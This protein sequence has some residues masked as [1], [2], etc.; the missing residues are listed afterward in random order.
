LSTKSTAKGG[1]PSSTARLYS[2]TLVREFCGARQMATVFC[3]PAW[4][5]WAT[6]SP[7]K[8]FQLRMPT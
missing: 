8:G 6:T 7:M 4:A 3:T 1:R 5:I 2:P